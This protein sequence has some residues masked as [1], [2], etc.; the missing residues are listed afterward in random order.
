MQE[1]R[2]LRHKKAQVVVFRVENNKTYVLLLQTNP[3]RGSFWQNVT[4]SVDE[5]EDF[6]EGAVRELK[7]ETGIV[8]QTNEI[9]DL[10]FEFHDRWGKD[11]TERNYWC[12]TDSS[13]VNISKE[14]HQNYKWVEV[15][16]ISESHF[17][18]PSNY[19][20]FQFALRD[21]EKMKC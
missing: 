2:N 9:S 10:V 5:G 12:V 18:F 7:E 3:E 1:E 16:E 13:E 6:V 14:E 8:S 20:A 21:L 19:Q 11:V 15:S 4:G 17:K